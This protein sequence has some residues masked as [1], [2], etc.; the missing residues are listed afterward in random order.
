M[1]KLLITLFALCWVLCACSGGIAFKQKKLE[2]VY[3]DV[4]GDAYLFKDY[5]EYQEFIAELSADRPLT[6]AF[7]D[8]LNAYK[9]SYFENYYLILFFYRSASTTKVKISNVR[10][11]ETTAIIDVKV[12]EGRV[13]SGNINGRV[14]FLEVDKIYDIDDVECKYR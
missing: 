3:Y 2:N 12:R 10:L 1:K 11:I 6:T 14:F 13:V 4:D 7:A 9:E 8:Q 5:Q